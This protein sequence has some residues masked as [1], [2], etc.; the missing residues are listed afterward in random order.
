MNTPTVLRLGWASCAVCRLDRLLQRSVHLQRLW[1]SSGTCLSWC[2]FSTAAGPVTPAI[3]SRPYRLCLVLFCFIQDLSFH[4][5][6]F[7]HTALSVFF[8]GD[9]QRPFPVPSPVKAPPYRAQSAGWCLP[10]HL[11]RG[12]LFLSW[13]LPL[14]LGYSQ[15]LSLWFF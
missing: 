5:P 4:L 11:V 6:P 8:P 3:P 13:A 2:P 7:N 14:S 10:S 1:R 9:L 12:P 15:P